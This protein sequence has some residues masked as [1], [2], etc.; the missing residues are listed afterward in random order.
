MRERYCR[1]ATGLSEWQVRRLQRLKILAND[2]RPVILTENDRRLLNK[3]ISAIN[4]EGEGKT[5]H[6]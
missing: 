4:P 5:K 6:E 2:H 1:E 3:L